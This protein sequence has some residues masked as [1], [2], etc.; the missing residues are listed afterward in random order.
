MAA[1]L[2]DDAGFEQAMA[3][4][5]DLEGELL[6]GPSPA[7]SSGFSADLGHGRRETRHGPTSRRLA[8]SPRLVDRPPP[9]NLHHGDLI[10]LDLV[11]RR[12]ARQ[13][14]YQQAAG[15]LD[16]PQ[17]AKELA[18]LRGT[19]QREASN[20]DGYRALAAVSEAEE[21]AEKGDGPTALE[22][23]EAAGQWVLDV[24]TRIGIP[25]AVKAI[26]AAAGL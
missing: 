17:L 21:A 5:L 22:R 13:Q 12:R 3:R 11:P 7:R 2:D 24:A 26:Q 15:D 19:L 4:A 10:P 16:L 6:L 9:W 25:V 8:A 14:I 1:R 18:K 23:L 20:A